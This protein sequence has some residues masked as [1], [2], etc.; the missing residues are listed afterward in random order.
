MMKQLSFLFFLS[1]AF[2]VS[3]D[4]YPGKNW[5]QKTPEAVGLNQQRLD[6]LS[7]LAEGH[8]CVVRNGYM[9]FHW[10]D[11]SRR[12]DVASAVKPWYTH[13]L[14]KAIEDGKIKD[15]EDYVARFEPRLNQLNA[16]LHDKDS[17]IQWRHLACQTSCY[18]VRERPGEAYDYSDFNMALFFD[19]LFLSVYQSS[20]ERVDEEVLHPLL[21]DRLGCEDN[22]TFLA[23]GIDNRPGRLAISVRDFA[24]FGL[25]YLRKGYWNGQQLIR[26]EYA[27]MA[28]GN[29]LPN[30]IPR[31]AGE[32]AD[33]IPGQRSIGGG[34][35]QTD[36]F[37]S[38][39]YAWWINGIDREGKRHWPDAHPDAYGCFGHDGKRAMVVMPDLDLVVC[40]N[41]TKIE[42][43]EMENQALKRLT[44]A[45]EAANNE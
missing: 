37:G 30:S 22:P 6:E 3:A 11:E 7:Q 10:G 20:W 34:N 31:T 16:D 27:E 33:M 2:S 36:H 24:R 4:V 14:F 5:E 12:I 18:G 15:M 44:E 45:A 17:K 13:F 8:G 41:D 25:L 42:G 21:T 28:T 43:R 38:Y 29:P 9:V 40:W 35:N 26:R 32:S 23:F 1:L 19:T 39:S